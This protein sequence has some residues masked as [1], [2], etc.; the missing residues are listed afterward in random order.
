MAIYHLRVKYMKRTEGRSSVAASAYRACENIKDERTGT[1]HDY[2]RKRGL[3]HAEILLPDFMP[4]D[5][6]DRGTLWNTVERDLRQKNSQPCFEVE[7][8]LPRELTRDECVRLVRQYAIENFVSENLAVDF[9]IHRTTAS[10]GQEHPHAHI[11]V[12][13]RRWRED[14]RMGN[15]AGDLQDNPNLIKHIYRLED[16]GKIDEALLKSK[17]TNLA[18][19][20][21]NWAKL[22][23]D[24]LADSGSAARIDHRTLAAQKIEREATPNI[25][26]AYHRGLDR[27]TGWLAQKV[28][29]FKAIGFRNA[30]REQA[31][32]ISRNKPQYMAEFM[33]NMREHAKGMFDELSPEKGR[34]KEAG[35]ER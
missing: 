32:K 17:G 1:R 29:A 3:D 25:G 6:H 15:C 22:S 24:A 21:E 5:M 9:C 7:V 16:E 35:Y 27:V 13:T 2:S 11:L 18:R 33:A 12:S 10:D 8:A 23:N 30:M 14:G 28:E 4:E 34:E 19:W 31:A 20:R 26:L